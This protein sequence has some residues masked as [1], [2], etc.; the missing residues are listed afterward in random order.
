MS[1]VSDTS[2]TTLK[3]PTY[4]LQVSQKKKK[5]KKK[6]EKGLEKLFKGIIAYIFLT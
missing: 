6:R 1:T 4:I 3:G 2:G 5:K